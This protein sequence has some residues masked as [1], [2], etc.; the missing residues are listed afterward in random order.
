MMD[1]TFD[2]HGDQS[3]ISRGLA[4]LR[5]DVGHMR[6]IRE[7]E[8]REI[9]YRAALERAAQIL[10]DGDGIEREIF[11]R[12]IIDLLDRHGEMA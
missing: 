4:F 10:I 6:K 8:T 2:D 11:A 5:Q 9:R 1:M 12:Q 3:P 7:H